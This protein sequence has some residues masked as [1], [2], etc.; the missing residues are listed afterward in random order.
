VTKSPPWASKVSSE[1]LKRRTSES[2]T[3]KD[4]NSL[5]NTV[6][7]LKVLSMRLKK[8]F[9]FKFE[10]FFDLSEKVNK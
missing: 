1:G 10:P 9:A 2:F 5:S 4:V 3:A 8:V 6:A 7:Y